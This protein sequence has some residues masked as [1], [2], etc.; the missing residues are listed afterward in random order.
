M[1]SG[2]RQVVAAVCREPLREVV[3]LGRNPCYRAYLAQV[4]RLAHVPRRTPCSVTV[5]GYRLTV[6]DSGSFL[7]NYY[8]I[9]VQ[10]IY[11]FR[12]RV[13]RPVILDCGAHI[14]LGTLYFKSMFP[15][16]RVIA[17]EADPGVCQALESNLVRNGLHDVDVIN[18]AL[19][20]RSGVVTFVSE[21][22]DSGRVAVGQD[23]RSDRLIEVPTVRLWDHLARHVDLLKM[24]IE[25]AET[26][27]ISDSRDRLRNVDRLFVEYHSR[28]NEIQTLDELIGVLIGEGFRL[29]VHSVNPAPMPFVG[30]SVEDGMDLQLN[31]FA[32][33][34][35][36]TVR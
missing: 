19:W 24:D 16:A 9:F 29:H 35:K 11:R 33:R 6:P 25:G 4:T 20:D 23:V 18:K 10:N 22:G 15:Q 28:Q 14:G 31:L 1:I 27:V 17:F 32:W 2:I 3:R 5:R 36:G 34:A 26:R 7:S 8:A 13:E 12:A 21:G 30:L